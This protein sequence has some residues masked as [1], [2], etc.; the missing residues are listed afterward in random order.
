MRR[1]SNSNSKGR[2]ALCSTGGSGFGRLGSEDTAG[3]LLID[4]I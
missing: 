4:E 1:D 3:V 2:T